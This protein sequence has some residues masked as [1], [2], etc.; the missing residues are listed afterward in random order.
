MKMASGVPV[1]FLP[2]FYNNDYGILFMATDA[3]PQQ[4]AGS[5][6]GSG[7]LPWIQSMMGIIQK[8]LHDNHVYESLVLPLVKWVLWV[9]LPYGLCFLLLNFFTTLLAVSMVIYVNG[10]YRR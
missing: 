5:S 9:L 10:R 8:E 1:V 2:P 7:N 3:C 6:I 4:K